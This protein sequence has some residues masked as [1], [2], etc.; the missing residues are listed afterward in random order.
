MPL[1]SVD[2]LKMEQE[3]EGKVELPGVEPSAYDLPCQCSATEL[4]SHHLSTGTLIHRHQFRLPAAPSFS[5]FQLICHFK[6]G[7]QTVMAYD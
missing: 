6:E 5:I 1:Q 7:P 4:Q 2:L 3:Q